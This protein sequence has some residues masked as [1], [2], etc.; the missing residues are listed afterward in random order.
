MAR[1]RWFK[2]FARRLRW[3]G[4]YGRDWYWLDE[5]AYEGGLDITA[6]VS[7]LRYDIVIREDLITEY[8]AKRAR[9]A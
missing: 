3:P 9:Y 7:P 2:R 5:S 4:R 8:R 1:A 6:L